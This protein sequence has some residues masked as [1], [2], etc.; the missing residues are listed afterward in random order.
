MCESYKHIVDDTNG[1]SRK[2]LKKDLLEAMCEQ[3]LDGKAELDKAIV[4]KDD[5]R[6]INI[7]M[8][9]DNSLAYSFLE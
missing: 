6:G 4:T 9:N 2:E 8:T 7:V 1:K 3:R 5:M